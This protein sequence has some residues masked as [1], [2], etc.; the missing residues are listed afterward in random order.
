MT[1]RD[2]APTTPDC[3]VCERADDV[4][5]HENEYQGR[6]LCMGCML[7]FDGISAEWLRPKLERPDAHDEI[8]DARAALKEAADQ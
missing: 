2:P 6:F 4:R 5:R 1:Y 7:L 3:P 8:D